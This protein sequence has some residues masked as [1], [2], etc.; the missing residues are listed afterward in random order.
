M[1]VSWYKNVLTFKSIQHAI[2]GSTT[3]TPAAVLMSAAEMDKEIVMQT[4]SAPE[5]LF[6]FK[7]TAEMGSAE[8][9]I[10]VWQ[11]ELA[12]RFEQLGKW[13]YFLIAWFEIKNIYNAHFNLKSSWPTVN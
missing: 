4:M 9:P 10:A 5:I 3:T 1:S 8:E 7:I 12:V 13:V 2:V 6:V 11:R